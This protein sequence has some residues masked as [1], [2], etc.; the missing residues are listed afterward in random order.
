MSTPCLETALVPKQL[1][2]N[3]GNLL[4]FDLKVRS[5]SPKFC[6][7]DHTQMEKVLYTVIKTTP[8]LPYCPWTQWADR[9]SCCFFIC[10]ISVLVKSPETYTPLIPAIR[11]LYLLFLLDSGQCPDE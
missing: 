10:V 11:T 3:I 9:L 5:T 1:N 2:W 8:T 4:V 6:T 7:S